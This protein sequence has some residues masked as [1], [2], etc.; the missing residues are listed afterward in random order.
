MEKTLIEQY[1]KKLWLFFAFNFCF[2]LCV[3][4]S[5]VSFEAI[6]I[7]FLKIISEGTFIG[8]LSPILIFILNGVLSSNVKAILV[9]WNI[10][11]PL[12]GSK[13]FTVLAPKD[14]RIN[15][16]KLKEIIGKLP[17]SPKEQNN[18]WYSIYKKHQNKIVILNSHKNYLFARDM[19]SMSALF[20]ILIP[21][22]I[23]FLGING[24]WKFLYS[25]F[26]LLQYLLISLVA[27]NYGKRFVCNVLAEESTS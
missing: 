2:L 10:R 20:L 9:F 15:M 6:N 7:E 21:L 24:I 18:L 25:M 12:P 26:L 22:V 1:R 8:I 11:Y 13:A 14:E 16:D 5:S 19:T 4:A 23:I 27:R 3:N 17:T